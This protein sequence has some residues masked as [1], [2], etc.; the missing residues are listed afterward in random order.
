MPTRNFTTQYKN[1]FVVQSGGDGGDLG[2]IAATFLAGDQRRPQFFSALFFS[3]RKQKHK[4]T[5]PREDRGR[6]ETCRR[7]FSARLKTRFEVSSDSDKKKQKSQ[8]DQNQTDRF[9]VVGRNLHLMVSN[10]I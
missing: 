9:L 10:Q 3:E 1:N 7:N 5:Q 8:A 6:D 2:W 4:N